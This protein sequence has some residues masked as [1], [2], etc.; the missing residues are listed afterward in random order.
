LE[1]PIND[2]NKN[3][4]ALMDLG[5]FDNHL[6]SSL[7]YFIQ[8]LRNK[9]K[10]NTIKFYKEQTLCDAILSYKKRMHE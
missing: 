9:H 7:S 2:F 8:T 5:M 10:L 1:E 3:N 4:D 6:I